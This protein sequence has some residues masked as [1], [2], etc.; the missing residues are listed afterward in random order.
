MFT[1]KGIKKI[2]K[3]GEMFNSM[4]QYLSPKEKDVVEDILTGVINKIFT[5]EILK[6]NT[7]VKTANKQ[8]N[9]KTTGV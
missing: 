9:G 8:N 6:S 7:P 1:N 5:S 4:K 3:I 2:K